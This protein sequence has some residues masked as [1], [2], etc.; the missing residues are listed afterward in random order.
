MPFTAR[1]GGAGQAV[2]NIRFA[3]A[4]AVLGRAAGQSSG[5]GKGRRMCGQDNEGAGKVV[6]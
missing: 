2:P 6:E 3:V 1:H 4:V 5:R